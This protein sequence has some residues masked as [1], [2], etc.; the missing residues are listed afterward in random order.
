VNKSKKVYLIY[1]SNNKIYPFF[2]SASLAL[3]SELLKAGY[4]P[5]II[6]VEL[7]GWKHVDL[8]D[9]LCV[10]IST[11]TGPWLGKAIEIAK[12]I[13]SKFPSKKI[14][15]GGPHVVALPELT[16]KHELVDAVC[17]TEGEK[18]IV[19][20]V[21]KVYENN[22]DYSSVKGLIYRSKDG[23]LVKTGAPELVS[24]DEVEFPPYELLDMKLYSFKKGR[25]YYQSARGCPHRCTFCRYEHSDKWHAASAEK[26]I[27][28]LKKF[29]ELFDPEEVQFF[30]GDFFI[31]I[32]RVRKILK[33]KIEEGLK[34][35]WTAF[36]RFD[37]FERLTDE[38]LK[39]LKD[40]NC[41]E[42]KFGGESGS[43]KVLAYVNKDTK[44]EQILNGVIRCEKYGIVPTLSFMTGFPV[45]TH[46]DALETINL[47][48][49]LK[50]EHPL[51]GVNG[52]YMLWHLPNTPLTK[53]VVKNYNIKQPETLEG[54]VDYHL[55]WSTKEEYPWLSSRE[56]SWRRTMSSIV[57]YL[58]VTEIITNMPKTQ[59]KNSLFKSDILFYLFCTLDKAVRNTFVRLRWE[60]QFSFFPI[61]WRIW[62]FAAQKIAKLI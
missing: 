2:P 9:A 41:R 46:E 4:E 23:S 10:C 25:I 51:T 19:D 26:V 20:L 43:A 8:S 14:F 58:Y 5:V 15:W 30:D 48:K 31:S 29:V 62:D 52:F 17:Y 22:E 60:M 36:C 50:K 38:D 42:L 34:L 32:E 21:N 35:N 37:T 33:L 61:E 39:L 6:D 49:K 12:D 18:V 59:R 57:T 44:P 47:I 1:T 53:E 24:M 55:L 11:F 45:E 7:S 3:A 13:K 54:W 56:Y 16:A 28:D 40:S 27:A